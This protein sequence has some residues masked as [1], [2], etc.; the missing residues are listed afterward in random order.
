[1]ENTLEQILSCSSRLIFLVAE[2]RQEKIEL[3]SELQVGERGHY[4]SR[5]VQDE[6]GGGNT[7]E[8]H[9]SV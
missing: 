4:H 9:R 7:E 1:M 5:R 2:V 6:S 8:G 3:E